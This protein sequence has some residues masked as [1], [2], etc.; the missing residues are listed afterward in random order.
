MNYQVSYVDKHTA[1]IKEI[2]VD[3]NSKEEVI[4]FFKD[5]G[6]IKSISYQPK[7]VEAFY[8]PGSSLFFTEDGDGTGVRKFPPKM[9]GGVIIIEK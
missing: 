4:E 8:C 5:K 1:T 3:A 7:R 9:E 6:I 2:S